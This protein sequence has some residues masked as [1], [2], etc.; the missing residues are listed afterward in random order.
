MRRAS[1]RASARRH[2]GAGA[3]ST[4]SRSSC[5]SQ[6]SVSVDEQLDERLR[7]RARIVVAAGDQRHEAL[8]EARA[9]DRVD[10]VASSGARERKFVD[11]T[12]AAPV[13]REPRAPLAEQRDIGVAKAVDRLEL[14]ADGEQVAA[15]EGRRGS[16]SGARWCPGARPPSG[17]SKR[18]RPL[19]ADLLV[20]RQQGARLELEVVEVDHP[21]AALERLVAPAERPRAAGPG[22][23]PPRRRAGRRRPPRRRAARR[24]VASLAGQTSALA[25]VAQGELRDAQRRRGDRPARQLC[26][27]RE[28]IE[29]PIDRLGGRRG[30]ELGGELASGARQRR[31][32]GPLV[33]AH[34]RDAERR[35]SLA[36]AAQLVVDRVD[37]D[38]QLDDAERRGEVERAPSLVEPAGRARRRTPLAQRRPPG[39]RR[40]RV[41]SGASPASTACERSSRAQKPWK[42]DTNAPRSRAPPRARRRRRAARGRARAAR[43][44]RDR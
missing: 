43:R 29:R 40:A 17:S 24:L 12:P 31:R 19:R 14:V 7:R 6:P 22:A 42:V 13:C 9:E 34:G 26:C 33:M 25:A 16:P 4:P 8:A 18:S 36:A 2:S 39:R 1:R 15:V 30:S 28:L 27:G 3:S 35:R 44:P 5:G 10:R 21:A 20:L 37:R 23:R 11:S 38:A 41:K 32:G